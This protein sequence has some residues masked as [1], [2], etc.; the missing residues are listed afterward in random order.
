MSV[1]DAFLDELLEAGD[2]CFDDL[3]FD[4]AET[5]EDD[6][7]PNPSYRH[8]SMPSIK[9]GDIFH[10]LKAF[11]HAVRDQAILERWEAKTIRSQKDYVRMVC[12]FHKEGCP[13]RSR[14]N[15]DSKMDEARVTIWSGEHNCYDLV[16]LQR[17]LVARLEFLLE[18]V[19]KLLTVDRKTS[20][21]SI[22]DLILRH[23]EVEV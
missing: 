17:P 2:S 19:P 4:L 18:L 22:Q 6:P 16:R 9:V 15:W 3:G 11:K 5:L 14:Y 20:V 21:T 13:W 8:N 10:D 1:T 7:I 23:T 12:F